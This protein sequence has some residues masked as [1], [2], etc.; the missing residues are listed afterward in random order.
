MLDA[1]DRLRGILDRMGAS[2][3][4]M[5]RPD[6]IQLDLLELP[7]LEPKLSAV[8]VKRV[9]C[10]LR[11]LAIR[12]LERK[13][14]DHFTE[15]LEQAFRENA[16]ELGSWSNRQVAHLD[17]AYSAQARQLLA[18]GRGDVHPDLQG[19]QQD[20]SALARGARWL[21]HVWC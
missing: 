21:S 20:L 12:S 3:G 17:A 9:G 11:K 4:A 6:E 14:R 5:T 7:I 10:P 8:E 13:L 16:H 2:A 15:P 18:R 1:R 19:L